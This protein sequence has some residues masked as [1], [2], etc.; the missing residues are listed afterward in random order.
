MLIR[1]RTLTFSKLK[2]VALAIWAL[3][4]ESIKVSTWT[5]PVD[6]WR[7]IALT[8][9]VNSTDMWGGLTQYNLTERDKLFRAYINFNSKMDQ[10]PASQN[11]IGMSWGPNRGY[12]LRGILTNSDAIS[13]APAFDEYKTIS[14][15]S[16]TSRV[17]AVAEIVPEFTGPTP[18]GL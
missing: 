13:N 15:I 6:M 7:L 10:D 3:L 9:A 16:S 11:I 1:L 8:E 5:I 14:N 17:A 4:P 2:R 18:L 12:T